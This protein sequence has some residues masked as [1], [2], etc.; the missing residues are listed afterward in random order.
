MSRK[1]KIFKNIQKVLFLHKFSTFSFQN[2]H[3][4]SKPLY[5]TENTKL[6]I[7]APTEHFKF[8]KV[9]VEGPKGTLSLL[10]P[11][12]IKINNDSSS[13]K[14]VVSVE[15][16][17][18]KKQRS[19]WGTARSLLSN[20]IIGVTKYHFVTL[21][22]VGVGYKASIEDGGFLSLKIGF[23]VPIVLKIKEGV[24]A[25]C[26][27]PTQIIL[28]GCDKAVVTQFA[29]SIRKWR[30]PEPYKGKGI[31]INDETIVLKSVKTK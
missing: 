8:K 10:F 14:V 6:H 2:S 20:M 26:P 17:T 12:Y 25:T 9:I 16:P 3:I 28:H 11:P 1:K 18:I 15:E 24:S 31:F 7:I 5:L 29:A 27:Q 21:R 19:M 22:L 13:N 4:G 23:S 30:K